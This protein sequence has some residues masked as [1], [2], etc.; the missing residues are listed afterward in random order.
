MHTYQLKVITAGIT[1]VYPL[2]TVPDAISQGDT[3]LPGLD[4]PDAVAS[5]IDALGLWNEL[6][7]YAYAEGEA[8]AGQWEDADTGC[9]TGTWE[10]LMDNHSATFAEIEASFYD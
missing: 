7:L 6:P 3:W 10:I 4:M 2:V 9:I 5:E 1:R 8:T